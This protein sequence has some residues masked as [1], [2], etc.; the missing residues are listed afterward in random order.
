MSISRGGDTIEQVDM[1]VEAD[2]S[3]LAV[4]VAWA[5]TRKHEDFLIYGLAH[6]VKDEVPSPE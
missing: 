5:A 1:V 6:E 2:E 3:R 4:A